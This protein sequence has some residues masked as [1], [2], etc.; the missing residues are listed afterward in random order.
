[1][2]DIYFFIDN[3]MFSENKFYS[4]SFLFLIIIFLINFI[5]FIYKSYI[6]LKFRHYINSFEND[7]WC[8]RSNMFDIHKSS[9]KLKH[10]SI[11][12]L[13]Y[14]EGFGSFYNIYK[15]NPNF[16][17]S[18]AIDLTKN[19]M[20]SVLLKYTNKNLFH[21][22][23]MYFS[24]IFIL[25]CSFF[26]SLFSLID[27][28][29]IMTNEAP[30]DILIYPLMC[31]MFFAILSFVNYFF[32]CILDHYSERLNSK[33]EIFILDFTNYLHKNFYYKEESIIE[34]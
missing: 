32:A 21:I 30:I 5:F 29:K 18:S 25:F 6:I 24:A 33:C 23:I 26:I 2:S 8:G 3:F 17:I 14:N 28:L 11:V 15:K 27:I 9:E 16:K 31:F 34:D 10:T 19:T 20:E 1:M 4:F 13:M 7:F 22:N 12:A